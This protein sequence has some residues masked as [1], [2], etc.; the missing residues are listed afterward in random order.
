MSV[1]VVDFDSEKVGG[2]ELERG[3]ETTISSTQYFPWF[4]LP[5]QGSRITKQRE[6]IREADC[7]IEN[8]ICELYWG[9]AS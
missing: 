7:E 6:E 4:S 9:I 8:S 2:K 3:S 5:T 1:K